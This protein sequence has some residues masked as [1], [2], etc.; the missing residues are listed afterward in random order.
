[1]LKWSFGASIKK[2]C[3]PVLV[4]WSH[5]LR[6]IVRYPVLRD[7]FKIEHWI[8]NKKTYIKRHLVLY[9]TS[10]CCVQ[11]QLCG[12]CLWFWLKR[13]MRMILWIKI[14]LQKW[15]W[16]MTLQKWR[17]KMTSQA[18]TM[19]FADGIISDYSFNS[20]F[21]GVVY[22][23]LYCIKFYLIFLRRWN[24]FTTKDVEI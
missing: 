20:K 12:L 5:L 21:G 2:D 19:L 11:G 1:M 4:Y 24:V 22:D 9:D 14:T 3:P 16:K 10:G 15:C 8:H 17:C 23:R 7:T 13:K 18:L 6:C